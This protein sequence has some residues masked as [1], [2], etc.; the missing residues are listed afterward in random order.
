MKKKQLILHGEGYTSPCS[1]FR[2]FEETH[3]QLEANWDVKA[4][5]PLHFLKVAEDRQHPCLEN[6]GTHQFPMNIRN[7]FFNSF[8]RDFFSKLNLPFIVIDLEQEHSLKIKKSFFSFLRKLLLPVDIYICY[9]P[10]TTIDSLL[11]IIPRNLHKRIHLLITPEKSTSPQEILN[12]SQETKEIIVKKQ[13]EFPSFS[14][15]LIL[16]HSFFKPA[17]QSLAKNE[18]FDGLFFYNAS[19]YPELVNA[20]LSCHLSLLIPKLEAHIEN[21]SLPKNETTPFTTKTNSHYETEKKPS[22]PPSFNGLLKG[23]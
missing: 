1:F 7:S 15:K 16:A 9:R 5:V 19:I 10:T 11:K 23:N 2:W 4:C 21:D 14:P 8:I 18:I 17:T 6:Y 20:T 13:P 3:S 12:W 22:S